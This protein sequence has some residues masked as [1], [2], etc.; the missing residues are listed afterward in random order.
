MPCQTLAALQSPGQ[1]ART[2]QALRRPQPRPTSFAFQAHNERVRY[3]EA[4]A[5][6]PP[7]LLLEPRRPLLNQLRNPAPEEPA[8]RS[9]RLV[10]GMLLWIAGRPVLATAQRV[11]PQALSQ[12][13]GRLADMAGVPRPRP[14]ILTGRDGAQ[15]ISTARAVRATRR[16]RDKTT[17]WVRPGPVPA[18]RL[19]EAR[20]AG[21]GWISGTLARPRGVSLFETAAGIDRAQKARAALRTLGAAFGAPRLRRLVARYG[22]GPGGPHRY[23]LPHARAQARFQA[24]FDGADKGFRIDA[25]ESKVIL[26]TGSSPTYGE[27]LPA[28]VDRI[29]SLRDPRGRSFLDLGA[30]VGRAVV[31]AGL[32]YPLARAHGI[33]LSD[34]RV[35][36]GRAALDALRSQ[37]GRPW[38]HIQLF[39]GDLLE[40]DVRPYDIIFIS[41]LCFDDLFNQKIGAKFDRELHGGVEVFSSKRVESQ[42]GLALR[43]LEGVPMS[44][45][46]RSSLYR[47]V[48]Y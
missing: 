37:T 34:T 42:R 4:P 17:C 16:T 38:S 12:G 11:R 15:V 21:L 6:A 39:A 29:F 23:G 43:K 25:A 7:V 45:N 14:L 47:T 13:I 5:E 31:S 46:P 3:A 44:W 24:A 30:G 18:L 1:L 27:L 36:T 2:F 10:T 48:W 20:P 9:G 28:G 32:G 35:A 41:N 26:D 33:E 22:N 19:G 8:F 40:L